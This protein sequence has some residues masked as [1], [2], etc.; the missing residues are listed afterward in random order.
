MS[1]EKSDRPYALDAESHADLNRLPPESPA[2]EK[3]RVLNESALPNSSGSEA[4]GGED[5]A[6]L[7]KQMSYELKRMQLETAQQAEVLDRIG[8]LYGEVKILGFTFRSLKVPLWF[9]CVV[10]GLVCAVFLH[11][12]Y[13]MS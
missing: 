8:Q 4:A 10:V 5:L 7:E 9:S 13:W 2:D 12:A 1:L 6:L 11:V 3:P